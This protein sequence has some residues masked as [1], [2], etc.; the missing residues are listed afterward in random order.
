MFYVCKA[1]I[2]FFQGQWLVMV[3]ESTYCLDIRKGEV[4]PHNL[5][6]AFLQFV[7]SLLL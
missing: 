1:L 2:K 5:A 6:S 3:S 4:F 7:N